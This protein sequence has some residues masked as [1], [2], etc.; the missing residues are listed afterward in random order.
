MK[1]NIILLASILL[2][3][4]TT[5]RATDRPNFV[6]IFADDLGWGDLGCYGHPLLKT[7]YLD[8]MAS[9]GLLLTNLM[10]P[11]RCVLLP[12]PRS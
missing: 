2:L 5:L 1:K 4:A 7:P 3:S 10:W 11:T 9:E 8:Q 12:G 6:F